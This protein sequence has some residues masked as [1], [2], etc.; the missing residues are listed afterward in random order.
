MF[1]TFYSKLLIVLKKKTVS[2]LQ[3][4]ELWFSLSQNQTHQNQ[5]AASMWGYSAVSV[6]ISVRTTWGWVK[7]QKLESIFIIKPFTSSINHQPE[8]NSSPPFTFSSWFLL[9]KLQPLHLITTWPTLLSQNC[10]TL[11]ARS[12]CCHSAIITGQRSRQFPNHRQLW[13]T[14]VE[15]SCPQLHQSQFL[16]RSIWKQSASCSKPQI[17]YYFAFCCFIRERR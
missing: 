13:N 15:D 3:T 6:E 17:S 12:L 1:D 14:S 8:A 10:Q 9:S 7:K 2:K 16:T 4:A 5:I 11:T